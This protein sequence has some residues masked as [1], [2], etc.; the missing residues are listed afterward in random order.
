MT[1]QRQWLWFYQ[2]DGAHDDND[3]NDDKYVHN[4]I[5]SPLGLSAAGCLSKTESI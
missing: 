3:D 1:V 4:N 5:H 2:N